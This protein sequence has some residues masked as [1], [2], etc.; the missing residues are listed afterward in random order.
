MTSAILGVCVRIICDSPL[1]FWAATFILPALAGSQ[2]E[3]GAAVK[4]GKL[5]HG[6]IGPLGV[7]THLSKHQLH[8]NCLEHPTWLVDRAPHS[9]CTAFKLSDPL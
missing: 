8:P 2:V 6:L 9:T 5:R 1:K 7:V 4:L 3:E